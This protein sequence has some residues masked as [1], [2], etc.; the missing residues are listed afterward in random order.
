MAYV[1]VFWKTVI[2]GTAGLTAIEMYKLCIG[3][4]QKS[5]KNNFL[6]L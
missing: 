2:L 1:F 5:C 3:K 6:A 4:V